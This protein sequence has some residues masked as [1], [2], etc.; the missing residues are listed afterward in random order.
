MCPKHADSRDGRLSNISGAHHQGYNEK[1]GEALIKMLGGGQRSDAISLFFPLS[2]MITASYL[3]LSQVSTVL[4]C[5]GIQS[6]KHPTLDFGS[7]HDLTICG[8]EPHI[9]PRNDSEEPA[10]DSLSLCPSRV[11]ALSK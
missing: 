10:W 2:Y 1:L 8:F 9:G 6:V 11:L 5:L 3:L 4:G 7:G